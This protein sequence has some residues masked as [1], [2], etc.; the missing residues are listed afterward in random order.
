ME[1]DAMRSLWS[2]VKYAARTLA[3]RPAFTLFS[4]L[5]LAL[6]I[7]ATTAIFSVVDAVLLRPLAYPEAESLVKING[8]RR[9]DGALPTNL[10]RPDF[11]DFESMAATFESMDAH[12]AGIGAF[13]LTGDGEPER[14]AAVSVSG[15]FFSTLRAMP[16]AGRLFTRVEDAPSA[17]RIVVIS[18]A[19]WQQ[20][21]GGASNAVGRSMLVNGQPYEIV[22]VLAPGFRFPQPDPE[23]EPQVYALFSFGPEPGRS[24]RHLRAVGRLKPGVTV[25]EA[26]TELST[27]ASRLEAAYPQTNFEAG[28]LVRGLADAI[29][30]GSRRAL[31]MLLAACG[32]VL[33]IACANLANLLLARGTSRRK[34]IAIRGALG[35]GRWRII[36]Q[37]LA[38]SAL[39]GA[40]GGAAGLCLAWGSLGALARLGATS[41]PRASEIGMD[42]RVLA[43]AAAVSLVTAGLFGLAP[44][45][46]LARSDLQSGLRDGTRDGGSIATTRLRGGLIALE[47]AL[48]VVLLVG[49]GLIAQHFARLVRTEPGFATSQVLTLQLSLP[50]ARYA[51]GRQI[52]FYERLYE[53]LRTLP[54]VETVGA[55]NIL[56]LSGNYSCDG[57]QIVGRPVPDGQ[58]PCAEMR[59][60]NFD[61]FRALDVPLLSGRT[62]VPQDSA[63]VPS[64]VVINEAMARTHFAG[65]D[66]IGQSIVYGQPGQPNSTRRIVGV[67]GNVRHF[68]L[69]REPTPEFY[70]PQRQQPSYHTMTLAL[71]LAP[72]FDGSTLPPSIR[73]EV[74]AMDPLLPLYNIR[75]M[76]SLL[77]QSVSE[78]RFRTVVLGAFAALAWALALVG[79]YGVV[80]YLVGQRAREIAIR[81]A[82]GATRNDV[83]RLVVG[84]GMRPVT[85][86]VVAG[87]AAAVPLGRVIASTIE[88]T[89][90]FE[91]V[92]F[93]AV[94]LAIVGA[95]AVASLVPARRA[96]GIE[97]MAAMGGER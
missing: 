18:H 61:Y 9:Q 20:R 93:V 63:D 46:Q 94:P 13:T 56:P 17:P 21:F 92:T 87:L 79:V 24:G 14:V 8:L 34:E 35:A 37:L 58:Q 41:I 73:S 97:P 29:T 86:G 39:L 68:A 74:A 26:Q 15:G 31:L 75:T 19:L 81:I 33:L 38:E 42:W 77:A 78:P 62:F 90:A 82:L 30:G 36:R 95:A 5:T 60:V 51:E 89:R 28:V 23:R 2:D 4:A 45:L 66:P 88:G 3:G 91:P 57:F 11:K 50:T 69:D 52:G 1:H 70:M 7:G 85:V 10:S 47:V 44:A 64:V 54:G 53:R 27:I 80:A 55:V 49:A 96:A 72:G 25:T 65:Q 6:G 16:A 12:G 67:A 40:L 22:G 43:F 48:A 71:R 59:S 76:N 32:L 83:M 84:E